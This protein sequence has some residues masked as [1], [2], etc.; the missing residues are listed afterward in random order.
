MNEDSRRDAVIDACRWL[1]DAGFTSGT[2]GNVSVRVSGGP[3]GTFL[4]TPTGVAWDRITADGLVPVDGAAGPPPD[5]SPSCEWRLHAAIYHRR[6]DVGA[7]VHT[8]PR[9]A[10]ALSC[11]RR[12]IPP[13]HYMVAA[14]GGPEIPCA[15]YATFGTQ[16]LAEMVAA[17]LGSRYR[18]C[19]M[20]NHGLVAV[21]A[22]PDSAL[23]LA[24]LVETLADQYLLALA[25]GDPIPLDEP[26]IDR[27]I[28]QFAVYADAPP[29]AASLRLEPAGP[30]RARPADIAPATRSTRIGLWEGGE[31]ARAAAAPPATSA[32]GPGAAESV[33][34]ADPDTIDRPA[35]LVLLAHGSPD[36]DWKRGLLEVADRLGREQR[37]AVRVAFLQ[38]DRPD[39]PSLARELRKE[40]IDRIRLIPV[41]YAEGKH[42]RADVP[43]LVR[44]VEADGTSVE[45]L[46]APGELEEFDDVLLTLLGRIAAAP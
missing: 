38:F 23:A 3:A 39:L 29:A 8:H 19:L 4:V 5:A 43:E 1:A 15:G 27:V 18:A 34:A 37:G 11:L 9:A 35:P 6:P 24:R 12:P 28:K 32:A 40:G 14:A 31:D 25:A 42:L 33:A 22:D 26:E 21:G 45:L 44:T 36:P 10:T 2:S 7:V 20:A 13:F 16:A 17:A 30:G 41:F 46:E